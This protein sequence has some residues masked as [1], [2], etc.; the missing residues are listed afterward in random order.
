MISSRWQLWFETRSYLTLRLRFNLHLIV[1]LNSKQHRF[2]LSIHIFFHFASNRALS[3]FCLGIPT[4]IS[5]IHMFYN[6]EKNI[7]FI[8]FLKHKESFSYSTAHP[9]RSVDFSS[10]YFKLIFLHILQ[11]CIFL[12]TS[13]FSFSSIIVFKKSQKF[14]K[15]KM[16]NAFF[17]HLNLS[18]RFFFEAHQL[19]EFE[20]FSSYLLSLCMEFS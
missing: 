16:I 3:F 1:L 5:C 2:F 15:L 8:I 6:W 7:C 18:S 19:R 14:I 11:L 20:N 10:G 4:L 17:S 12:F 9:G 13:V